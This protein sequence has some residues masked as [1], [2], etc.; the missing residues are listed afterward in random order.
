[1]AVLTGVDFNSFNVDDAAG[2]PR[3]LK[4][5][6]KT[7][8][9]GRAKN[10]QDITT[11]DDQNMRRLALRGDETL[12]ITFNVDDAGNSSY[13]VLVKDESGSRTI[14]FETAAS[15]INYTGEFLM[16]S[17]TLSVADDGSLEGTATFQLA[18]AVKPA[19]T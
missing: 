15:G 4:G 16:E 6:V 11:I 13:D 14:T 17:L 18:D 3:D 8:N 12:D 7:V 10:L 19:F 1:M 2:M 9:I 5:A